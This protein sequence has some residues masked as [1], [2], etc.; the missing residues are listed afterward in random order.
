[1]LNAYLH[2]SRIF[3][4]MSHPLFNVSSGSGGYKNVPNG[5]RQGQILTNISM[6]N[7]KLT[8]KVT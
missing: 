6:R 3:N 4:K 5:A 2:F 8:I 7:Q 1:M